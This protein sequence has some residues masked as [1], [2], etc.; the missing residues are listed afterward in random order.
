MIGN[1]QK[2]GTAEEASQEFDILL[3]DLEIN[4]VSRMLIKGAAMKMV[5]A[6]MSEVQEEIRNFDN[7]LEADEW[8]GDSE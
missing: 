3:G 8:P 1:L 4:D 7:G 2:I 6:G 5:Y